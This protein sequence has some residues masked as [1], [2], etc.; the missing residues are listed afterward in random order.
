[1][2]G[3]LKKAWSSGNFVMVYDS[4]DREG[5]IDLMIPSSAIT[6][7]KIAFMRIHGGGLICNAI[8]WDLART[9][10][11]DFLEDILNYYSTKNDTI[12]HLLLNRPRYDQRSS[13]SITINHVDSFTGITDVDRAMTIKELGHLAKRFEQG[14]DLATIKREFVNS[15]RIPGH[16]HVL[17]AARDLLNERQGHTELAIYLSK[18]A[19]VEPSIA[20]VE[21]LDAE[22]GKALS[23]KKGKQFAREWGIPLVSTSDILNMLEEVP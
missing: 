11:I 15:F 12:S 19:G 10:G 13:F 7:K 23:L 16:V 4:D 18:L 3:E 21:M 2:M 9:F 14:I 8:S 20:M 6:P 17:I 1:M 5:E 22:T